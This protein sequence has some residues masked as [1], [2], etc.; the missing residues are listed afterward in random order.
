MIDSLFRAQSRPVVC[1]E[2]FDL[3]LE[4]LDALHDASL[5]DRLRSVTDLDERALAGWL[6]DISIT[7]REIMHELNQRDQA[8]S[9][10]HDYH[11]AR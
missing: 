7:A 4:M 6:Q 3:F 2:D 5:T 9:A 1:S 8:P 10:H 11:S